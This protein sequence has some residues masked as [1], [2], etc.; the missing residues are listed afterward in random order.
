MKA[1]DREAFGAGIVHIVGAGPGDAGLITV[2][3]RELIERAD[4]IVFDSSVSRALLPSGAR[5]SGHPALYF[6]GRRRNESRRTSQRQVQEL[7]VGLARSGKRVVRLTGGDPFVFGRG[8]DEAQALYDAS[9]PFEVVPGITAGVAALSYAGIPVTH[10]GLGASVTFVSG[11]EVPG[12]GATQTDWAALAKSGGTIVIYMGVKTV[13]AISEALLE[14]G[15]PEEIPAA[16]VERG[17][18]KTQR[19]VTATLGDL[20]ESVRIAGLTGPTILVVGWPVIL[21]EEMNWFENRP[22]FGRRIVI[23]DPQSQTGVIAERLR[24]L[25]AEV[26]HVPERLVIRLDLTPLREAMSRLADYQWLLFATRDAVAI[27]WEQLLGSGRD[28]R[29]LAGLS[30]A[31]AGADAAA[32]LLER[33]ITVDVIPPGFTEDSLIEKLGER[34]DIDGSSV[35]LVS[36]ETFDSGLVVYLAERGAQV[37]GIDAYRSVADEAAVRRFRRSL[38]RVRADA[39]VFLSAPGVRSYVAAAGQ[40]NV[41]H[42]SAASIGGRVTEE[43]TAAGL[44]IICEASEPTSDSLVAAIRRSLA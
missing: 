41:E 13:A 29:A 5:E 37:A 4:A 6:V 40:D 34:D 1:L 30:V 42:T 36:P 28:A 9:V 14:G 26:L 15:M 19:T 17:T 7:L 2:R 16:A 44:Q 33:G 23:A 27:F 35:L 39:V 18:R 43:L 24:D 10:R 38:A 31:A 20:A 8:G 22:L 25:G 12:R 32:A 21:R 11:R 3:G